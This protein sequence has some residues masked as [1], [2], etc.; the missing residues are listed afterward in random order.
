MSDGI[1]FMY[2]TALDLALKKIKAEVA[3]GG[4][5]GVAARWPRKHPAPPLLSEL[6]S[7]LYCDPKVRRQC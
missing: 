3:S 1:A 2:A 4:A 5:A 6:P 7:P